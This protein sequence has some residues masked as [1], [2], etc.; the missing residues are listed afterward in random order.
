M[1]GH[2]IGGLCLRSWSAQEIDAA[3]YDHAYYTL[4]EPLS[5]QSDRFGLIT[6]PAGL[7]T[8]FASIPKAAWGILDPESP[9][10]QWPSVI[11]DAGYS[12]VGAFSTITLGR[13]QVDWLLRDM[14]ESCGADSF[15]RNA[16][17]DAVRIGGASHW[18]N[19][20]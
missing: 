3:G 20:S 7:V 13:E 15:L 12:N 1:S 16:V 8:D 10:I 11:H 5:Y 14:M 9:L 18:I 6:A 4:V 17:Y 19:H 2:F